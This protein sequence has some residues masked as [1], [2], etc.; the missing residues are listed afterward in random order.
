MKRF[1]VLLLACFLLLTLSGCDKLGLGGPEKAKPSPSI[2]VGAAQIGTA[3]PTESLQAGVVAPATIGPTER[4]RAVTKTAIV[5]KQQTVLAQYTLAAES[6]SV[7]ETGT[8][9][10]E[11]PA[12]TPGTAT[13]IPPATTAPALA[14]TPTATIA[15]AATSTLALSPR[16]TS[17]I[18]QRGDTLYRLSLRFN[19][20]TETL[21]A[22][23]GLSY[24]YGILAGQTLTI[25]A[26]DDWVSA[27][28]YTVRQGDSLVIIAQAWQLDWRDLAQ[29]NGL[30]WPYR[31]FP[32]QEL[33]IPLARPG[34]LTPWPNLTPCLPTGTASPT[35]T[36][37][38]P[39]PSPTATAVPVAAMTPLPGWAVYNI[40]AGDFSLHYPSSW[41]VTPDTVNV[42]SVGPGDRHAVRPSGATGMLILGNEGGVLVIGSHL[43][44]PASLLEFWQDRIKGLLPGSSQAS[45]IDDIVWD[46]TV[47]GQLGGHPAKQALGTMTV[48]MTGEPDSVMKVWLGAVV[49]GGRNYGVY[50]KSPEGEWAVSY[51]AVFRTMIDTFV[52]R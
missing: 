19:V 30:Y 33:I 2:S 7:A 10:A 11:V 37:A 40:H 17:Y 52:L 35:A 45:S 47:S 6:Q 20:R 36:S 49:H 29:A 22:A 46:T 24:P 34:D 26:A 39:T 41:A 28:L 42:D 1:L 18:V 3:V 51:A 4:A 5:F 13:A 9:T 31:I 25:P 43:S 27:S 38:P 16:P 12:A 8:P 23:N 14:A 32:G 50:F 48:K 21:A 44:D 15:P